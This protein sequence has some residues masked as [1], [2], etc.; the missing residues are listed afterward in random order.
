MFRS[1]FSEDIFKQKYAHQGCHTW[2]DL[3]KTLVDDVCGEF[4]PKDELLTHLALADL[5]VF[6]SSCETFGIT[7]LEGM[8][9]GLP[10][11]CSNRSSLPETLR[12]GGV[13]FDPEDEESIAMAIEQIIQSP[14]LRSA[15]AQRAKTLS[16]EYSWKRCADETFSFIAEVFLRAKR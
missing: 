15:I 9:A 12:D 5:F 10:I 7:L 1:K 3:A 2:A 6:A 11:A 16:Q 8:A 4:L 13:Y 14:A